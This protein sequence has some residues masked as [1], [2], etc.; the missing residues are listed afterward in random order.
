[1]IFKV[2]RD[3]R[4]DENSEINGFCVGIQA[5]TTLFTSEPLTKFV[6]LLPLFLGSAGLEALILKGGILTA[7]AP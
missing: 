6:I 7:E 3:A 2:G 5:S 4:D 1:M